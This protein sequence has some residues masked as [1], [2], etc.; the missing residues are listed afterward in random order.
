MP[1]CVRPLSDGL[2]NGVGVEEYEKHEQRVGKALLDAYPKPED[3]IRVLLHWYGSGAGPWS[4][5]PAYESEVEARLL[6][7]PVAD[8]VAVGSNASLTTT[9]LEGVARLLSGPRFLRK[10]PKG[11]A[12]VPEPIK[13]RLLAH[14]LI[15]PD[16]FNRKRAAAAFQ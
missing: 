1:S 12:L 16:E 3:R 4:G 2:G 13:K 10:H 8:L 6:E 7:F 14:S 11:L 9:E 5:F 15:S